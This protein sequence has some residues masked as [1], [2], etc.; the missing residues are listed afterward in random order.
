MLTVLVDLVDGRV[1]V[2]QLPAGLVVHVRDYDHRRRWVAGTGTGVVE[3]ELDGAVVTPISIPSGVELVVDDYDCGVFGETFRR[4]EDDRPTLART[5]DWD[6]L[7]QA[8]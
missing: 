2:A 6:E 4:G 8:A 3:L 7:R 1:V 5:G